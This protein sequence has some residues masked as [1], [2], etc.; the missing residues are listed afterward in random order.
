MI[1]SL[2]ICSTDICSYSLKTELLFALSL[3]SFSAFQFVTLISLLLVPCNLLPAS[4][5]KV[6]YLLLIIK[7]STS[8]SCFSFLQ[9]TSKYLCSSHFFSIDL[10]IS[11]MILQPEVLS[12]TGN[13][14]NH[15]F[16]YLN[17]EFIAACLILFSF[18]S[19]TLLLSLFTDNSL[20]FIGLTGL[21]K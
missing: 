5:S 17:S 7:I 4:L 1:T 21:T 15:K 13:L 18:L 10:S 2:F 8:L 9:Y 19:G 6:K 20:L 3:N 11:C 14:Q 12:N 16:T